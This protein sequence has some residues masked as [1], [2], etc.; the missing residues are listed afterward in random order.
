M[1]AFID[2]D[3]RA[4]ERLFRMLS[5]RVLGVLLHLGRDPRLA[6]DLTQV[7]FLK[8]F[9]ARAAYQ[10]G[11]LVPPWVFAIARN[12]FFDHQRS[13]RCRPEALSKDGVLPEQAVE[14]SPEV[15]EPWHDS[16]VRKFLEALPEA[17]R[18]V[19]VL[20]KVEG[21]TVAEAAAVCGTTE[22]SI[23]M[24]AHRAYQTLRRGARGGSS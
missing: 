5:P 15:V 2:G 23:K 13:R 22:A 20:L 16:P 6:E 8:L 10:R 19:L 1:Q 3:T 21:L 4:F 7:T 9:R 18:Q 12:T 24:R 14:A 17:Q 11:M